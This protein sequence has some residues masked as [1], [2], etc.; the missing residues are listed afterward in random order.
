MHQ[1]TDTKGREYAVEV[2]TYAVGAVRKARIGLDPDGGGEP[3]DLLQLVEPDGI[4]RLVRDPVLLVDIL[5]VVCEDQ[6]KEHGIDAREFARSMRGDAIET[7]TVALLRETV[8][9]IPNPQ[10]RAARLRVLEAFL[11]GREKLIRR[12]GAE[13]V[14]EAIA[15]L[16]SELTKSGASSGTAPE[17]SESIPGG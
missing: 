1:F 6:I 13:L 12:L 3:V 5:A 7:A 9:F 4:L 17:S 11:G 10:E 14:P 15:R 2:D 8:S 16:E